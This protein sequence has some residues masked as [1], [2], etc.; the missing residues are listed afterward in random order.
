MT[1]LA[2]AQEQL[3]RALARH[4]VEFVVVGGVAAQIHGWQGATADLDIAVSDEDSNVTRLN[5]ALASVNA[6]EPIVGGL[7]TVFT[8]RYGR[9]EVISRA[10]GI[11]DYA[12]WL[13]Q[14]SEQIVAEGLAVLA[15]A[16]QDI[17]RSKQ[18]AGRDKDRAAL[19]QMRRDLIASG[20][21]APGA[22]DGPVV[23]PHDESTSSAPPAFLIALLGDRPEDATKAA[24]W[25]LAAQLVLDHRTR[26]RIDDHENALGTHTP[27]GDEATD[28]AQ[29]YRQLERSRRRLN[30]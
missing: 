12:A 7:G 10:D 6:S 30:R 14:A 27:E 16:P 28:C 19:P 15:A 21:I 9:L 3:L 8:T 18:A 11:G 24:T 4:R 29:L 26:W 5:Q 17:L 13:S 23:A 25:D 20:A 22:A 1:S 2:P